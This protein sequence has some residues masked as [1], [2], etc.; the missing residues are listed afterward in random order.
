MSNVVGITGNMALVN[1]MTAREVYGKALVEIGRENDSIVVLT[2]DLMRSNK[3]GAFKAAFPARFFNVGISE[4]DMVGMAAGMALWGKVPFVTT[5]AKF[6]AMRACEQVHTDVAYQNLNVNIVATHAGVTSTGGGTHYALEDLAIMRSMAN[7]TVIVPGDPNQVGKAVRA[8]AERPGPSYIRIGRGMEP[9]V[10]E[11]QDYEYVIG[12]AITV[13]DGADA[14]VIACGICV[15]NAL[16]A[17]TELEA[18]GIKVRVIDMHTIKPLDAEA[19]LKAARDTGVIVTA[20]EHSIVGGLGSAVADVL[21]EAG[22][23]IKFRKLGF[24]D[25]FAAYGPPEEL[26][27]KHGIDPAGI[28]RQVRSML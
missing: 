8:V 14:T 5:F 25:E 13:K 23:G 4:Q 12:K 2:A 27:A 9:V 22:F 20:E 28:V 24:P 6:A 26:Y 11:S 3:T 17:A 16:A 1:M 7:M 18:S 10:Y 19:V 21:A 15:F